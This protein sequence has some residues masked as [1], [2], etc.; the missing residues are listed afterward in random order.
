MIYES[1]TLLAFIVSS[2]IGT[3]C[4]IRGL[5]ID[6]KGASI[7]LLF[8]NVI[9]GFGLDWGV[10][11]GHIGRWGMLGGVLIVVS[12]VGCVMMKTGCSAFA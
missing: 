7:K 10:F 3:H 2:L 6:K 9:M 8:I 1:I 12:S 5:S 11:G 4:L